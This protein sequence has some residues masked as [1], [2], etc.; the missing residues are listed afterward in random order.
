[1]ITREGLRNPAPPPATPS[2]QELVLNDIEFV[3]ESLSWWWFDW[4]IFV[5]RMVVVLP[6]VYLYWYGI[7]WIGERLLAAMIIAWKINELHS[8]V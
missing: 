2:W 1:M 8:L 3:K 5:K 7:F 6:A 4:G